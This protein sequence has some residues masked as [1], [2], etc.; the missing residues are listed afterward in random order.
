MKTTVIAEGLNENHVAQ[1][2]RILIVPAFFSKTEH[3]QYMILEHELCKKTSFSF[4]FYDL[5]MSFP[6]FL[7]P[8]HSLSLS[9]NVPLGFLALK[10]QKQT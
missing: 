8:S 9:G 6:P 2:W 3:I 5:Q 1:K 10:G 7:P 4:T